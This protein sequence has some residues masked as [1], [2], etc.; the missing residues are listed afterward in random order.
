MGRA[1]AA[2]R[3]VLAHNEGIVHRDLKPQNIVLTEAGIKLLDFGLAA[4]IEP[5]VTPADGTRRT[6]R[7]LVGS[8]QYMAPEQAM[9]AAT[10][11]AQAWSSSRC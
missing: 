4:F 2:T 10:G 8:A 9:L 1:T 7:V 3:L 5:A 11:S 6:R